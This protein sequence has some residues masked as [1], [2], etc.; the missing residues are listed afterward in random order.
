MV[1]L[2]DGGAARANG[3][4]PPRIGPR[5]GPLWV[6]RERYGLSERGVNGALWTGHASHHGPA[7]SPLD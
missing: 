7:G 2:A 1:G 5:R 4:G 6:G 3:D